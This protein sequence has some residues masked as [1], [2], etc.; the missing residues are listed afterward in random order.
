[1][2]TDLFTHPK[3]FKIAQMLGKDELYA[4]GALFA[5]WSWVDKHVVDGHV[6]GA[7]SQLVDRAT[8]VDGLSAALISVGWM[9][10]SDEGISI[11]EFE[12][13]NGDSAKERSLKNQRQ[14]R[15][16]AR[17]ADGLVDASP[18]TEAS[19]REE[20]RREEKKE[21]KQKTAR[22]AALSSSDLVAEGVDEETATEFLALRAKKRAP[23]TPKAWDGF[24]AEAEKAG[25]SL[26]DAVAKCLARGWQGFEAVWVQSESK[27]QAQRPPPLHAM[28]DTQL[29]TEGRRYGAGGAR[30]GES[31]HEYIG[32][33]Q[34]AMAAAQGRATE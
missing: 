22:V 29:D 23:L 3:V 15:W 26:Q 34:T 16:R 1:M 5:F 30:M 13:H 27:P 6:D 25:W 18:S 2:R 17:K 4:V 32:R 11:P 21:Q 9:S 14:A 7:T 10:V 24:K 33:I 19:T 20:K 12:E 31:R 28:T 8:R